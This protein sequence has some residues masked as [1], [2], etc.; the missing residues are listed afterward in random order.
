MFI[1]GPAEEYPRPLDSME[2]ACRLTDLSRKYKT[3]EIVRNNLQYKNELLLYKFELDDL[4]SSNI[5]LITKQSSNDN[6]FEEDE[7]IC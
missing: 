6:F 5:K 2:F 4:A 7:E 3:D 1:Q